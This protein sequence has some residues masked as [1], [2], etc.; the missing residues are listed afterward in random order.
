MD[1]QDFMLLLF[2]FLAAVMLTAKWYTQKYK[3]KITFLQIMLTTFV[4]V[5]GGFY[6]MIKNMGA[7]EKEN[8]VQNIQ[9]KNTVT[10]ITL[11]PH[12]PY[13]KSMTLDGGQY[14]PMPQAMN[15]VLQVGDSVYK[16]K[17]ETFYTVVSLK[18]NTRTKYEVQVHERVASKP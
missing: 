13:F 4:L 14:L 16:K 9:L 15:D 18:S 8:L 17:G 6:L 7:D 1:G 12:K 5:G 3:P 11:D 10:A 2:L